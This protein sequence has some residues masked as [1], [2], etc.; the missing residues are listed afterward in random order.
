MKRKIIIFLSAAGITAL[1]AW[2]VVFYLNKTILPIKVKQIIIEKAQLELNRRV[3]IEGFS[4]SFLKGFVLEGLTIFEK[5]SKTLPFLECEK[6][7]FNILFLPILKD[8]KIIIPSLKVTNPRI[9]IAHQKDNSWNF[10]DIPLQPQSP[11]AK[12][13]P[14][15]II[16]KISI[17]NGM[18]RFSDSATMPNFSETF[19]RIHLKANLSLP[20]NIKF[21]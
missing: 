17:F 16:T 12:S 6:I 2:G 21:F 13:A 5:D 4:F 20:R 18:L 9:H 19:E 8:R 10:S 15:L 7:A 3:S 1:L 14:S 11:Q